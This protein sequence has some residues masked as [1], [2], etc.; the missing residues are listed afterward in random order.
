MRERGVSD[1]ELVEIIQIAAIGNYLDT[2][3]DALKI[4]VDSAITDVLEQ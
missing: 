4:E 2:L 3:A 1:E